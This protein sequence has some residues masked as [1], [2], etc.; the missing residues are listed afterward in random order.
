[1]EVKMVFFCY[2]SLLRKQVEMV[3][4]KRESKRLKDGATE[5]K[6][7]RPQTSE[8]KLILIALNLLRFEEEINLQCY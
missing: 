5:L 7:I 2:V 3:R 6:L 1:M 4:K 8:R